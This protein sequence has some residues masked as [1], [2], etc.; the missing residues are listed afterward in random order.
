MSHQPIGTYKAFAISGV[1][2]KRD[3]VLSSDGFDTV[4]KALEH[5]LTRSADA[6][7]HYISANGFNRL[8]DTNVPRSEDDDVD[9]LSSVSSY[10]DETDK[11]RLGDSSLSL[12]SELESAYESVS[13]DDH[14]R[15]VRYVT[16]REGDIY[17]RPQEARRRRASVSS[18]RRAANE[19]SDFAHEGRQP[20]FPVHN[21]PVHRRRASPPR[22]PP[23][24]S[25]GGGHGNIPAGV[26]SPTFPGPVEGPPLMPPHQRGPL[27]NWAW[28]GPAS[29]QGPQPPQN[30][31]LG[32]GHTQ[33]NVNRMQQPPPPPPGAIMPMRSLATQCF[34]PQGPVPPM[35]MN[36]WQAM[37]GQLPVQQ[38]QP[39]QNPPTKN[40][41]Q[42]NNG[43]QGMQMPFLPAARAGPQPPAPSSASSQTSSSSA[44]STPTLTSS[45]KTTTSGDHTPKAPLSSPW[46]A[47]GCYVWPSDKIDY[48]LV[49][50]TSSSSSPSPSP[51]SSSPPSVLEDKQPDHRIIARTRPTRGNMQCV[52]VK[53]V[54]ANSAAFRRDGLRLTTPDALNLRATVTRAVFT[55]S[56]KE[57]SYDLAAYPEDDF[58]KLCE[59]M[60]GAN[61]GVGMSGWP[62]FEVL[63]EEVPMSNMM[64]GP[65]SM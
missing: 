38:Q 9:D 35:N 57:E 53:H 17:A 21:G 46:F 54:L 6:V 20:R 12:E 33:G 62:L 22:Y 26:R 45:P 7:Q 63:V 27:S 41:Y 51:S 18:P 44:S 34:P 55:V 1:R 60:A 2:R 37:G 13:E 43:P 36:G 30:L 25:A 39:P 40:I 50:R 16:A 52:A 5:L 58:G 56:G 47:S 28:R 31:G 65:V 23:V 10:V 15:D 49:I 59:S 64:N 48:R 11:D 4:T 61:E 29:G 3:L 14:G 8:N 19:P 32:S 24:H 42:V